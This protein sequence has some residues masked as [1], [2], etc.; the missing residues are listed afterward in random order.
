MTADGAADAPAWPDDCPWPPRDGRY[1]RP[2]GA[3]SD[4]RRLA[5]REVFALAEKLAEVIRIS[6]GLHAPID[7]PLWCARAGVELEWVRKFEEGRYLRTN[8]RATVQVRPGG[9]AGRRNFTVAHELGH[10]FLEE[11]RKEPTLR[12]RLSSPVLRWLSRISVGGRDEERFCDAF[13]AAILV[14]SA[15]VW[16]TG[17]TQGFTLRS[18]RAMARRYTVSEATIAI[19]ISQL[20]DETLLYLTCSQVGEGWQVD[21]C[22]GERAV[23]VESG[24]IRLPASAPDRGLTRGTWQGRE[25]TPVTLDLDRSSAGKLV[26]ILLAHRPIAPPSIGSWHRRSAPP[27]SSRPDRPGSSPTPPERS[28]AAGGEPSAR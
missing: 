24:L 10:H 16:E 18:V 3:I 23:D 17:R 20:T 2:P 9:N 22:A 21:Y 27:V 7:V 14:P 25:T 19:R 26:A 1:Q 13:A 11:A 12:R 4:R 15:V 28:G 5:D 6:R 8:P